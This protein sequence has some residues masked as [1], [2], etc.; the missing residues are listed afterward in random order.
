MRHFSHH[1]FL[2][3]GIIKTKERM[4]RMMLLLLL[5]P[6]CSLKGM[7][8]ENPVQT[9]TYLLGLR[10]NLLYDAL[11]LPTLGIE[12]R[13][14]PAMGI[15]LDGSRA[16][17][18]SQ[19]GRVQKVWLLSPEV[20][21]YLQQQRRLYLG[22]SANVGRYNIYKYILGGILSD[23]DTGYQGH[24]WSAGL[25]VGYQL[26]LARHLALDFG[27]GLGYTRSGYDSFTLQGDGTRTYKQRDRV[28][29]LWGPTQ[30]SVSLVWTVG[31]KNRLR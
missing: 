7:G 23:G 19:R 10:T 1:L 12:W 16:Q 11:A 28:K 3:S 31:G 27:L 9:D 26:P 18:G 2:P 29:N 21:W 24:L 22:L 30:V 25:T 5:L 13:I 20:R 14:S 4:K 6:L 17:W 8:Q 15:R